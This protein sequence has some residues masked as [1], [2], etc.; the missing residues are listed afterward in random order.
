MTFADLP[1]DR[2]G[3]R[4]SGLPRPARHIF[5]PSAARSADGLG[6]VVRFA[7]GVT[8]PVPRACAGGRGECFG[9]KKVAFMLKL[10]LWRADRNVNRERKYECV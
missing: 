5:H 10:L 4:L 1:L 8:V 7:P 2:F 9:G 6:A 3:C